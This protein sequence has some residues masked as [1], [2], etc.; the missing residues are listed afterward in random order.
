MGTIRI[1]GSN[2]IISG[3]NIVVSNGRVIVDGKDVTPDAKQIS[4]A[5]DGDVSSVSVDACERVDVKGSA[6]Q[7]KTQSGDV[8]CGNVEGS[9]STMSGD[10]NCGA[11][12][13]S[14]S[15]MS[16]DVISR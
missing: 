2:N 10:V 16:G 6:G 8:V 12:A 14:V 5:V 3:N 15:T 13:G 7:V 4:I 1:N 11:V 9:V